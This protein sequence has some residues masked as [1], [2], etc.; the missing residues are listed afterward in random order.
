M[1]LGLSGRVYLVTGGSRGLGRATAEVL[2]AEG[3]RVVLTGRD[4]AT[5]RSTA[6]TLGT[7][8]AI[9][10]DVDLG[11]ARGP[12]RLIATAAAKFG[13][14]DG[15]L[16]SSGGP[17]AGPSSGVGDAQWRDAFETVFLGTVRLARAVASAVGGDG[18][19]AFVLSASVR[20]PLPNLGISNG[21]RPGLAMVA[22]EL[23]VEY[24]PR[25]L[26]VNGLLPGRIDTDRVRTMDA[27]SGDAV[28]AARRATAAIPLGRSGRP[29]EFGRVAAFVLSPAASFVS[30]AMVAV[31]GG[32]TRAL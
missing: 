28:G 3:A 18:S 2:V 1:D 4:E 24:G 17:P 8:R 13:R 7:D 23:S 21:L 27:A 26:R 29:E 5:V 15:A 9:G 25:G 20:T 22:K 10:L 30:G 11:D 6:A 31:D 12:E 14:L 19:L 16:I 32:A